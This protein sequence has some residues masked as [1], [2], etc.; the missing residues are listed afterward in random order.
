MPWK[1]AIPK[2]LTCKVVKNF[3]MM[4]NDFPPKSGIGNYSSPRNIAIGMTLDHK[5]HFKLP[6]GDCAQVH[7]NKEPQNG[8][9]ECT[10]G[11]VSLRPIHSAHSEM[12]QLLK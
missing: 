6:F 5:M 2:S 1:W 3:V 7:Q 4:M 9:K 12:G 11:A 10:L 8:N